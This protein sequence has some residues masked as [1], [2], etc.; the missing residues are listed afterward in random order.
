[1]EYTIHKLACLAGVSTRTLRYYETCG[2]LKPGRVRSSGYRVYG[3]EEIDKLQMILFF[4][5]LGMSLEI[6]RG[7][8]TSGDFDRTRVLC[9]HRNLLMDRKVQLEKLIANVE[10][11]IEMQEGRA[12]MTDQ[13][14]FEGFTQKMIEENEEKYGK[15]IRNKYGNEAVDHSNQKLTNMTKDDNLRLAALTDELSLAIKTAF[16]EGDPA[17]LLSQKACGL[18]KKWLMYFWDSYSS[19]AHMALV[20]GY[21]DDARFTAY[22]DKIAPGCAVFLRDAMRIFTV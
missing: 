6:I 5:E 16:E 1:M 11:T 21:V 3:Q 18:H 8:L 15:E 20:Q 13:E 19:E 17:G 7:I 12:T 9:E 10:K 4:R 14:K 22:Y 2:L